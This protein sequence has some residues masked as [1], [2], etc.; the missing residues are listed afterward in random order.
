MIYINEWFPNPVGNDAAGEFVELYNSG[1]VSVPLAGYTLGDGAKK[2]FSLD[3]YS[4]PPGGYLSLTHAEDKLTLK[5][6]DGAL[7]LYGPDG[8]L[9]DNAAFA[10]AAPE[11][12]SYSRVDYSAAD[13]GHFAF[14]YPTPG[15]ANRTI[16]M[17]VATQSYPFGVPLTRP[18][19]IG[20]FVLLM[21]GVASF[22]L[23]FFIYVAYH[24]RNISHFLFGG[25]EKI[26]P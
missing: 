6:T 17:S 9:V 19:G 11:G 20:T 23:L 16:D 22:F 18:A 12:K 4:I 8:R 13:I 3:G 24:N 25:D 15:T 10:G 14:T 26:G 1:T 7:F 2:R 21:L 5:N